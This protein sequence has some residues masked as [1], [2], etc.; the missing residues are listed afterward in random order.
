M[1]YKLRE[2]SWRDDRRIGC[3]EDTT[4]LHRATRVFLASLLITF[5]S[6]APDVL[7][8]MADELDGLAA[9]MNSD[10][11]P[12]EPGAHEPSGG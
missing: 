2:R 10:D 8:Q 7:R 9:E 5:G 3:M 6:A 4:R 12:T 1:R 11:V